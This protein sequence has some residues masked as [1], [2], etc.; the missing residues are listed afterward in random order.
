MIFQQRLKEL[1]EEKGLSQ[2]QVDRE[3]NMGMGRCDCGGDY[4]CYCGNQ[5]KVVLARTRIVYIYYYITL[6]TY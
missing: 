3:R 2:A 4:A 1:R 6:V 5:K